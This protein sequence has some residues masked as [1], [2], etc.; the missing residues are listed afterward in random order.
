ML[1]KKP[2]LSTLLYLLILT[3]YI[4]QAKAS[5]KVDSHII[6]NRLAKI[7]SL[8][9]VSEEIFDKLK[10]TIIQEKIYHMTNEQWDQYT[11]TE[12][13]KDIQSL[14][15]QNYIP[16]TLSEIQQLSNPIKNEYFNYPEITETTQTN[17]YKRKKQSVRPYPPGFIQQK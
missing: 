9:Y 5:Q 14:F 10:N 15:H 6:D 2:I 11:S 12:L 13:K 8:P 4:N 16:V 7:L 3:V 17:N 1:K